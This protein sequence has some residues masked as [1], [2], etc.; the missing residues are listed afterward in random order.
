MMSYLEWKF[1]DKWKL[2]VNTDFLVN[3][4]ILC[5]IPRILKDAS[6]HS[7]ADHRKQFNTIIKTLFDGLS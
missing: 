4:W 1:C 5:V 2:R 3:G 6:D 7:D